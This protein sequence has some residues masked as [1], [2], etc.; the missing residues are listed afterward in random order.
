MT[1]LR[2]RPRFTLVVNADPDD[3]MRRFDEAL[4]TDDC[5]VHGALY[6]HQ[7]ELQPR[8]AHRHFWS[9]FL[10]V[11]VEETDDGGSELNGRFGPAPNV[12][13]MFMAGYGAC[14]FTAFGAF[15]IGTSQLT[16]GDPPTGFLLVVGAAIG[17][18][19]VYVAAQVG[20]RLGEDQMRELK[21][22]VD[23]ALDSAQ[24][25]EVTV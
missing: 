7:V 1:D 3:V 13:T 5:Q 10:N 11:V 4:S 21:T 2:M 23:G 18:G 17:A 9:P 14:A 8:R 25:D 16:L 19:V 15:F 20:R 22:F 12:W 6:K 24:T